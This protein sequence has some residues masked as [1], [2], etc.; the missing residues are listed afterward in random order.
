MKGAIKKLW[1]V[2][3]ELDKDIENYTVWEDYLLDLKLIPYDIKASIAHAKML[4]K[5]WVLKKDEL[6]KLIEWLNKILKLWEKWDFKISISE[7]DW[8]TAIEWFLTEHYW[9]LWKKIHTWRSRNDQILVT[10]RLFMMDEI[11]KIELLI[12]ELI[13]VLKS[14]S[15]KYEKVSM[16]WY[17]HTQKAMPTNIWMWLWSFADWLSDVL[18]FSKALKVFINKSPLWSASWFWIMNF[19]NDRKLTAKEM[20]FSCVQENPMYCGY[21]RWYFELQFLQTFSWVM[22]II[23]K[24]ANDFLMFTTQEFDFFALPANMTTWSSIMPQKRNY[25]IFEIIRWNISVYNS[26]ENQLKNI[27]MWLISWYHRDL[28]LTKK[29]FLDWV[30][31]LKDTIFITTKCINS[32]IVNE[33][34]LKKSMTDDLF[35]TEKV[36][37]LVNKWMSFRDAYKKIKISIFK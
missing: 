21:S 37:D 32:V 33:S 13:K 12:N 15:K 20:W 3:S 14:K 35:L 9:D 22:F 2:W 7:E 6:K 24:I 30:K 11:W 17:T 16:P 23:W 27:I 5:K 18:I 4:E 19:K 34:N 8:H 25:D 29:P 1:Q 36:Y 28:Q 31:L 10:M 26:Y